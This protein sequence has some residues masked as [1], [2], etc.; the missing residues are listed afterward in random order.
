MSKEMNASQEYATTNPIS[1][2]QVAERLSC[3]KR[4]VQY[5]AKEG[6]LP[7]LTIG[8]GEKRQGGLGIPADAV[9]AFITD[10]LA[11]AEAARE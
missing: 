7:Y 11:Q 8:L 3:T 4:P 6:E 10:R 5:L 2:A 1:I 9:D